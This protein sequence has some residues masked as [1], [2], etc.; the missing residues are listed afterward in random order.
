ME[1]A[2][3][4]DGLS[5]DN[6]RQSRRSHVSRRTL[7]T[8]T[9]VGALFASMLGGMSACGLSRAAKGAPT[10]A[11][12][13]IPPP[14]A[15][16]IYRDGQSCH[17]QAC[18]VDEFFCPQDARWSPDGTQVAVFSDCEGRGFTSN[19]IL[20]YDVSTGAL[21]NNI[22]LDSFVDQAP[23]A[24]RVCLG[25]T[26]PAAF[27]A[28]DVFWLPGNRIVMAGIYSVF[29]HVID[30]TYCG[31]DALLSVGMD[32]SAPQLLLHP[33]P[34]NAS[35]C[36]T[37]WDL[38]AGAPIPRAQATRGGFSCVP[39]ALGYQWASDGTPTPQTPL[40]AA[41]PSSVLQPAPV[42]NLAGGASFTIWQDGTVWLL[43]PGSGSANGSDVGVYAWG[44][45]FAALSPGGRYLLVGMLVEGR[46][47]PPGKPAPTAQT[48]AA[49]QL[50]FAPVLPLHDM[51]MRQVAAVLPPGP[52][53]GGT[54]TLAHLSWR[55]DGQMMAAQL[56]TMDSRTKLA[57]DVGHRLIIYASATGRA[58]ATL[59]PAEESAHTQLFDPPALLL[60]WSP[61]GK[62]LLLISGA[63]GAANL[64]DVSSLPR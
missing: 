19:R 31:W 10:Q 12:T 26:E 2:M 13:H 55:A 18:T 36:A 38:Q 42:G 21:R 22:S 24:P 62:H 33:R 34:E 37:I 23:N 63:R 29:G 40:S 35:D 32:G 49:L 20:I 4:C 61:D 57:S 15:L 28:K 44:A 60:R 11:A 43:V 53:Q 58:L 14:I 27:V 56:T 1:A 17:E 64:W 52:V 6:G 51:A 8:V 3:D 54:E 16:T 39:P 59:M 45:R 25:K 5:S 41:T 30:S 48:L 47:E 50:Q 7:L 9:L 46:L